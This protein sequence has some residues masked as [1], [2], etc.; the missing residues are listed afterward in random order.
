MAFDHGPSLQ[1]CQDLYGDLA[2]PSPYQFGYTATSD[3]GSHG[4]SETFDGTQRAEG[5]YFLKLADGRERTVTYTADEN[6]FHPEIQTN[7]LG[8]ESKNPGGALLKSSA[9]TGPDAAIQADSNV[10]Q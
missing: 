9:P 4:H 7:E 5:S 3:E 2:Q 6:G 1:H 10:R 8:T